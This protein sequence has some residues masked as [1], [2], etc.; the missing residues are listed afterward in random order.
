MWSALFCIGAKLGCDRESQEYQMIQT[1]STYHIQV[2]GKV[3]EAAFNLKSPL[4]VKVAQVGPEATVL[5]I[6][7]D[8]SGVIGLIRHLHGQGFVLLSVQR[9]A[10]TSI[11]PK[12][13][14]TNE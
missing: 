6:C 10:Y 14:S 8:Q 3:D 2:R 13:D 5:N 9:H 1:I 4:Q 11:F 12:E 7:A